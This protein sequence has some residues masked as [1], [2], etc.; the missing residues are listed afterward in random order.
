M[1]KLMRRGIYLALTASAALSA[2]ARADVTAEDVWSQWQTYFSSFGYTVNTQPVA[3]SA[4][5]RLPDLTISMAVP[6]NPTTG[7]AGG[8]VTFTMGSIALVNRGDGTVAIE[9]PGS[10]PMTITGEGNEDE[11]FEVRG[12]MTTTGYSTIASGTPDDI[13]YTF[14]ADQLQLQIDELIGKEGKSVTPDAFMVAMTDAAGTSRLA[15]TG[16][17]TAIDQTTTVGELSYDI[18]FSVPDGENPGHLKA[19]GGYSGLT[20]T[21]YG[22]IPADFD[23]MKM[24]EALSAGYAM[25]ADLSFATGQTA[26]DFT[27]PEQSM[28]FNSSSQGGSFAVGMSNAGMVYNVDTRDIVLSLEGSEIPFPINTTLGAFGFGITMPVAPG[29]EVQDF[30]ARLA[31]TDAAV[32][33]PLWMM[34]DAGNALPHDPLTAEIELSGKAKLFVNIMDQAALT[35]AAKSQTTPGEL[36]QLTLGKLLLKAAGA[37][38]TANGAFDVDNTARSPIN[39]DLPAFD[40][41]IDLRMTGVTTL[42]GQLGQMGLI[43]MPQAMMATGMI[44]QLGKPESGPDDLSAA[45]QVTKDAQITINGMPLPF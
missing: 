3:D 11:S 14:S 17:A 37:T 38:I 2:P 32:P 35:N 43:P 45:I 4:G 7:V 40:G 6:A 20:S 16:D 13:T 21:A 39:P 25:N 34:I 19:K 18:D 42:L 27:D 24:D 23:P 1:T 36:S 9:V 10:L 28:A 41:Q 29:D 30:S 44:Q 26:L 15:Q 33:E 12:S 31:L 5:L 22:N 8:D